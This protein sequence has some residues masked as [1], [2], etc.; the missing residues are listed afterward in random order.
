MPSLT[1]RLAWPMK[2]LYKHYVRLQSLPRVIP[3]KCAYNRC[4]EWFC[5]SALTI[6]ASSDS[7]QVRLQS[8]PRVIPYTCGYNRCLGDSVHVHL[9]SLPRWFRTSALTLAASVCL[10]TCAY[11]RCLGDSVHV[12]LQSLPRWVC[13]RA[14]TIR[15]QWNSE[16]LTG[17]TN[18]TFC[19]R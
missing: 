18:K 8:L 11:N 9:Q 6:A 12:R 2:S 10:Y 1:L 15:P 14:L 13:T 4:L 3:Y 19:H 17:T 7:V 16:V 5:T